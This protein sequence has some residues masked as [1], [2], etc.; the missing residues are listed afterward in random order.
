MEIRHRPVTESEPA[1]QRVLSGRKSKNVLAQVE[2]PCILI[3]CVPLLRISMGAGLP[4]RQ[5]KISKGFYPKP[6][7]PVA[8]PFPSQKGGAVIQK[9][10]CQMT[11]DLPHPMIW[12]SLL[13]SVP[14]RG[15]PRSQYASASP[16]S[17]PCQLPPCLGA[18][19]EGP[20]SCRDGLW[21]PPMQYFIAP[22]LVRDMVFLPFSS[23]HQSCSAE[24]DTSSSRTALLPG[25]S[26]GCSQSPCPALVPAPRALITLPAEC[27]VTQNPLLDRKS[28]V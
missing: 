5:G 24:T 27:L 3:Y 4:E 20:S 1:S 17:A 8:F 21:F 10:A 14:P 28:V 2:P 6:A 9:L 12:E 19:S 16:S 23:P 13:R 15:S 7:T 18:P 25:Q 11:V 26:Q 22:V